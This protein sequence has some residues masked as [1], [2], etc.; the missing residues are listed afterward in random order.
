MA[1]GSVLADHGASGGIADAWAAARELGMRIHLHVE[2]KT[3]GA[4]VIADAGGSGLMGEDV[5]LVHPSG[6]DD[7]DADAVAASG[8]SVSIAPS[9]ETARGLAGDADPAP[10]RP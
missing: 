2:P 5:T 6:L 4:S 3:V 1:F 8:A 9:S 10:D 7:A